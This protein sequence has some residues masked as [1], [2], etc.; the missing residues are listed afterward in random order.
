MTDQHWDCTDV[1]LSAVRRP[2]LDLEP[3]EVPEAGAFQGTSRLV[4]PS[5][6]PGVDHRRR[7]GVGPYCTGASTAR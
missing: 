6:E 1:P 2:M 4:L 3:S 7:C 5:L